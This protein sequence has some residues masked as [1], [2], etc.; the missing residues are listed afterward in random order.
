MKYLLYTN[1]DEDVGCHSFKVKNISNYD[2]KN[3][4]NMRK[5]FEKDTMNFYVTCSEE[6]YEKC[7]RLIDEFC[8]SEDQD[9]YTQYK[10]KNYE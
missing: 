3:I 7:L 2:Q 6:K 1:F 4:E 10:G 9:Q 5:E 8:R